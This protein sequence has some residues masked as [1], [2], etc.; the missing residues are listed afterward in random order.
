MRHPDYDPETI[1]VRG[2][3]AQNSAR[4]FSELHSFGSTGREFAG[5]PGNSCGGMD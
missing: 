2:H 4:P 5:A 3:R 1:A